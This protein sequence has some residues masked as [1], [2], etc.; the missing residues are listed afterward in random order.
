MAHL[1]NVLQIPNWLE[2]LY[3]RQFFRKAITARLIFLVCLSSGFPCVTR[4]LDKLQKFPLPLR[5]RPDFSSRHS[6]CY[7]IRPFLRYPLC[8]CSVPPK[9]PLASARLASTGH[10]TG[11]GHSCRFTV[12]IIEGSSFYSFCKY[13]QHFPA[14]LMTHLLKVSFNLSRQYQF[15]SLLNAQSLYLQIRDFGSFV[16][17][18]TLSYIISTYTVLSL[19]YV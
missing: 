19:F 7:P 14:H 6:W 12:C 2:E 9:K 8:L 17:N 18:C 15:L 1:S 5:S 3:I 13:F 11:C 4:L 16:H 10:G